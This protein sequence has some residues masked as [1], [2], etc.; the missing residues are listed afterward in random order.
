MD[1]YERDLMKLWICQPEWPVCLFDP[2]FR[3]KNPT[4]LSFR[5]K[6]DLNELLIDNY[7][8]GSNSHL[9]QEQSM[10]KPGLI[11]NVDRNT[12]DEMLIERNFHLCQHEDYQFF[13]HNFKVRYEARDPTLFANP[14]FTEFLEDDTRIP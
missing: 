4:Y 9:Q 11:I 14:M 7:F 2:T 13:V 10:F 12:R 8:Y 1:R 5:V 6:Q 3:N